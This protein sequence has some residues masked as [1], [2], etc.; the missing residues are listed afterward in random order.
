MKSFLWLTENFWEILHFWHQIR[1]DDAQETG[2]V[3]G[4]ILSNPVQNQYRAPPSLTYPVP[5]ND[6]RQLFD[7]SLKIVSICITFKIFLIWKWIFFVV[8]AVEC[9]LK[10]KPISIQYIIIN[11][12]THCRW[13]SSN[14]KFKLPKVASEVLSECVRGTIC[15]FILRNWPISS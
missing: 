12:L 5:H 3:G 13:G 4:I 8:F 15:C 14:T 6:I 10:S 11:W 1:G 2:G 9:L 7:D